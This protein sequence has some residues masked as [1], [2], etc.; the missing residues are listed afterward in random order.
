LVRA[1]KGSRSLGGSRIR[2]YKRLLVV[3]QFNWEECGFDLGN[4]RP[5][6]AM[7][8]KKTEIEFVRS[9]V[10]E[11]GSSLVG[12]DGDNFPITVFRPMVRWDGSGV[13][14]YDGPFQMKECP[15]FCVAVGALEEQFRPFVYGIDRK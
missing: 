7:N 6:Y 5:C 4:Q 8:V 14:I 13:E 1:V 15:S 3:K 10:F 2:D 9:R 11:A 12:R